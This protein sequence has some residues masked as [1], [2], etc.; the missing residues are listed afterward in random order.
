MSFAYTFAAKS[1]KDSPCKGRNNHSIGQRPMHN[2]SFGLALE[3]RHIPFG[4]LFLNA[5]ACSPEQCL[6][7]YKVYFFINLVSLMTAGS[8][9]W[10]H[11]RAKVLFR[12]YPFI[13][14]N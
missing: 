8:S 13:Q 5:G 10:T 12:F 14:Q 4:V 3:E 6:L 2:A 9:P 11:P 1:M 7:K